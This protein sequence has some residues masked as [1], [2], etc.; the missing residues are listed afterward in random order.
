MLLVILSLNSCGDIIKGHIIVQKVELNNEEVSRE[1][2][3]I[4]T[5][6]G[7]LLSRET[8]LYTNTNYK[9]GDTLK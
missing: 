7:E 5:L 9:V 8:S 1:F 3:Y 2:K 4:V 6:D